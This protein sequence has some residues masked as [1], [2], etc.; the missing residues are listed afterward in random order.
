MVKCL[1]C[2][3]PGS[4]SLINDLDLDLSGYSFLSKSDHQKPKPWFSQGS[5]YASN[6]LKGSAPLRVMAAPSFP[7]EVITPAQPQR[8][9]P[10]SGLLTSDLSLAAQEVWLVLYL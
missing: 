6:P 3:A 8:A 4:K 10:G 5:W 1:Y 7:Y 2:K 9:L